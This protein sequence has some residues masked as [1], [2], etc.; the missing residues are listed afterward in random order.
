MDTK[1]LLKTNII[2]LKKFR[3]SN[4]VSYFD[5]KNNIVLYQLL[6]ISLM[7]K[8]WII[9]KEY[10]QSNAYISDNIWGRHAYIDIT[11]GRHITITN[12][13]DKIDNTR[14]RHLAIIKNW[15]N[16]NTLSNN[17]SNKTYMLKQILCNVKEIC[18]KRD[19]FEFK[20]KNT[21]FCFKIRQKSFQCMFSPFNIKL[22]GNYV[23][24]KY[25]FLIKIQ[26]Y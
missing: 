17:L 2:E 9:N 10:K 26:I 5:E 23:K 25:N 18:I 14:R 1:T 13:K 8:W 4:L 16:K 12:W 22:I 7:C 21:H 11:K 15:K 3:G 24:Y 19:I 20:I 6:Y